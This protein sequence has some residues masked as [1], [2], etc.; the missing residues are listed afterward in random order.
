VTTKSSDYSDPPKTYQGVYL[1]LSLKWSDTHEHLLWWCADNSG[2]TAD[3]DKAGRYTAEQVTKNPNYYDNDD[4]TR[5]VPLY[6]VMEG[7]VGP[8][9]RIVDTTFRYP[10]RAYDCCGC[11][12]EVKMRKD[13]RFSP[14]ACRKCGDGICE[15]CYDVGACSKELEASSGG[16]ATEEDGP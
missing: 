5:A 1:I 9:R 10:T 13:P 11:G 6:D 3:I 8:I 2:Y 12:R 16:S 4:T 14:A 15:Y 7:L